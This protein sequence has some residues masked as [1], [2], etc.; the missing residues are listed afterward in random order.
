M[1]EIIN[2]SKFI[3][4]SEKVFSAKVSSKQFQLLNRSGNLKI[5]MKYPYEND[6]VW[7]YDNEMEVRDGDIIYCHTEAL[8][9]LFSKLL[10]T[11]VKNLTLISHQSDRRVNKKLWRKKPNNIN[12]WFS[13]NVVFQSD[14]LVGIPLGVCNDYTENYDLENFI[15]GNSTREDLLFINFRI[16]TNF[17]ERNYAFKHLKKIA[18][19]KMNIPQSN[20]FQQILKSKFISAPWGNGFDTHRLWESLY[21][22][23]IPITRNH[24][25]YK[26]FNDLPILFVSSWKKINRSY[27]LQKYEDLIFQPENIKKLKF[28]YWENFILN[29]KISPE[30]TELTYLLDTDITK[31]IKNFNKR[32]RYKS[33]LK[34]ITTFKYKYFTL[35]NYTKY[36]KS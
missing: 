7:F 18:T 6:A 4:F 15:G 23:C 1:S 20:F 14:D 26:N 34:K 17:K 8:E 11:D 13:T 16:N 3:S 5:I 10:N 28:S 22:G 29:E 24:F 12:K 2:G 25:S 9:L 19:P 35:S 21:L 31:D 33:N 30:S 36:L 32:V 27:L